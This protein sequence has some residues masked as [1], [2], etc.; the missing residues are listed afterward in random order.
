VSERFGGIVAAIKSG[1]R[2]GR[3]EAEAILALGPE[4]LP[5]LLEAAS[6]LRAAFR[7]NTLKT[8]AIINAKS[9]RCGEDCGFCAQSA[10][11]ATRIEA[12]PLVSPER[13]LSSARRE[14]GHSKRFGI[15]TAGKRLKAEEIEAVR[16]TVERF[17]TS[18]LTQLPCASL[19][20]L[21]EAELRSLA[22]AGLTRYHHNLETSQR[23]YPSICST[24]S[25]RERVETI[26]AARKAGLETCV[27]GIW[28]LGESDADRIDLLYEIAELDPDSVPINFL[29]PIAGTP[30]QSREPIALWE[31]VK[32]IALARFIMPGKDIKL[33]AGRPEIFRDAQHLVFLAGAN[34]MI[35]G[36]LLTVKGRQV[37]DDLRIAR[38]LGL[39]ISA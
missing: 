35:V 22:Q 37:A 24:H 25:Y 29:V 14:E 33:G 8:C 9:G 4:H 18:G 10:H 13:M 36:N 15:V 12:Y 7:G 1:K 21:D 2:L 16:R 39:R 27:G 30:L 26:R 6:D 20:T 5:A 31:A 23:F 19:G 11:H 17:G 34:G 38:D 32:V 28:G 3:I